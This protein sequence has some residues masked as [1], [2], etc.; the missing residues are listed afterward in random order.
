MYKINDEQI[1]RYKKHLKKEE[2]ADATIAKYIHDLQ[3]MLL[4]T[5][6]RISK[7]LLI[8]YKEHLKKEG[9]YKLSSINSFLAAINHFLKYMN[10][11]ECCVKSYRMQ[12]TM[13][14]PECRC[15]TKNDYFCL[16][17]TARKQKNIRL[18]CLLQT[19]GATGIRVSELRYVTVEGV[20]QG[21]IT[22]FSKGKC[23]NI[24]LPQ[25]L[26]KL[27][28]DFSKEN[29]Y[30]TGIIFRTSKGNPVDRSNVW[31]EMKRLAQTA[32]INEE[33][34]FPHNLRHLFAKT[35][36]EIDHDLAKLSELLGHSSIVTTQIYIRSSMYEHQK[37]LEMM[38]LIP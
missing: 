18:S 30:E 27:L 34:I 15:L 10:W 3:K 20:K 35:F 28:L 9:N 21:V 37:K 25:Q 13:F 32:G 8:C 24:L 6:N 1:E 22:I 4:Y 7:E 26:R 19:I 38:H 16:I 17:E 33:K 11:N 12:R 5:D 36:Y 29:G 31:K 2:K 23:R 14:E